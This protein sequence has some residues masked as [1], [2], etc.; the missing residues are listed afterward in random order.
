MPDYP[1]VRRAPAG[2][3]VARLAGVSQSA[4]SRAFTPGASVA[5]DTKN[6]FV[7]AAQSLGY[8]PNLV[9]RLLATRRT[10]IVALAISNFEN[11]FYVQVVKALSDRLH[12]AIPEKFVW[13]NS[14]RFCRERQPRRLGGRAA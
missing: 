3:D 6:K 4:V 1:D 13:G 10:N 9:A 11:P 7:I 14:R 2:R 5:E 8:M 12:G